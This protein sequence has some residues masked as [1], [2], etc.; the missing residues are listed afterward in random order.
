MNMT[1]AYLSI[2]A[3]PEY[4]NEFWNMMRNKKTTD[5]VLAK[6]VLNQTDT[7]QIP[8]DSS[9]KLMKALEKESLFRKIS[10]V[11]KAYETG[12]KIF[13]KDC[14]DMHCRA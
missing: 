9:D 5:T 1:T 2:T 12:Y 11:V 10:T 14:K 6:G 8:N 3:Q 7:F 4:T 13:A